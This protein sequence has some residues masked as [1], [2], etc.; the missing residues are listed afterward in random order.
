MN[1]T[2]E[3]DRNRLSRAVV[4]SFKNLDPF[5]NLVR[6]L[7]QDYTGPG[8]GW[9]IA[10]QRVNPIN[11]LNQAVDA[12]TM[13]LA[14]N[15]PR[16]MIS[17]H[18]RDL[19]G[20][21]KHFEVAMNNLI[22][23]IGLELT[24]RQAVLDAFFCVGI[25]KVHIAD[26]ALVQ[27]ER[28]RWMDPGQPFASNV[29]MDNWVHDMSAVRYSQVQFAGDM[30]RVPLDDLESD[31]YDQKVVRELRDSKV[32]GG[33]TKYGG[34]DGERLERISRGYEVDQ[35]ELQPMVDLLDLWVPR[36]RKVFTF[37]VN[38]GDFSLKLPPVAVIDWSVPEHGPYRLL[39]FGD[40]PENIMPNSPA[41]HMAELNRLA[42][43]LYRK[44]ASSAEAAK[45]VHLYGP[46][47][48]ESAENI[49]RARHN[50]FVAAQ[51]PRDV[52]TMKLGGVDANTQAFAENVIAMFDRMAGNLGAMLGLGPQAETARQEILIHGAVSKKEAQLQ[53]RALEFAIGIVQDLGA[54]LW[55]DEAKVVPGRIE[56]DGAAGYEADATW[57]PGDREG[58][59]SDYDISVDVY[60]MPYQSPGQRAQA[61][62]TLLQTIYVPLSQM[63]AQQGWQIDVAGLRELHAELTNEP[64]LRNV[65]TRVSPT[66]TPGG[67]GV[68]GSPITQ[69]TYTHQRVPTQGTPQGQSHASEMAWLAASKSGQMQQQ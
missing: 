30:Y 61:I 10:E 20:F 2:K 69:R 9:G 15:R 43:N 6:G 42:N 36:E 4:A 29:A 35:D 62:N 32:L 45:D 38:A 21:A 27:L 48:K 59:F 18:D 31:L 28:D 50:E 47:G 46:S 39:G 55:H 19:A 1:P 25:A 5:R 37:P 24:L 44:Q 16:V 12:Y 67:E 58:E 54:L 52:Q 11:L 53:A 3:T 8:Y 13:S 66:Q 26:S 57:Y 49:Q 33:T 60:S 41:L 64:K 51:D 23:E 65:I 56:I 14:A 40:V 34:A 63:M 22:K 7:V 68:P 17:T